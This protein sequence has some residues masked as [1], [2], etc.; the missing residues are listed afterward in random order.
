MK[1]SGLYNEEYFLFYGA[2]SGSLRLFR[3]S[4]PLGP[5]P[6]CAQSSGWLTPPLHS[7]A[8]FIFVFFRKFRTYIAENALLN[9]I[10]RHKIVGEKL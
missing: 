4:L 7:R 9:Q 5:F 2:R 3:G 6:R 1:R 10:N 8:G